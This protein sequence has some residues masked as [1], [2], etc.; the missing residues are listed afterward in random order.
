MDKQHHHDYKNKPTLFHLTTF[1]N[2]PNIL[3]YGL[4][5][6]YELGNHSGILKRDVA[7]KDI[8]EFRKEHDITKYIPFHFMIH[9]PFAGDV[10]TDPCKSNATF[11][12][13]VISRKYAEA[14]GFKII[15][16]HP[17][18]RE[19]K[20]SHEVPL[21][22]YKE[23]FEKI[24]WDNMDK[25]AFNDYD[26]KIACLAECVSDH[27]LNIKKMMKTGNASFAVKS[28]ENKEKLISICINLYGRETRSFF[29]RHIWV[30]NFF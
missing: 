6:R 17:M 13:I 9:S 28:Q 5:S 18:C 27:H 21:Y 12:Y 20:S 25:R 29:D 4:R 16:K 7:N 24:D 30:P 10:M 26:S 14:N 1:D 19:Y 3:Q 11:V 22:D 15:P 2:I 23:G 8:I